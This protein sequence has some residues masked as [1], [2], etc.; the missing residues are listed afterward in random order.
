MKEMKD[1]EEKVEV[2]EVMVVEERVKVVVEMEHWEEHR[3]AVKI[4]SAE[5][6]LLPSRGFYLPGNNVIDP[7]RERRRKRR[8][9]GGRVLRGEKQKG[10]R[11]KRVDKGEGGGVRK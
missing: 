8:G 3:L 4:T 5:K 2:V 7:V 10:R 1:L 6:C 9:G 11:R